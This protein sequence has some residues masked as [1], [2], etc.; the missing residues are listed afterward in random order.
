[1]T[2]SA[3]ITT[4]VVQDVLIVPNWAVQTDQTSDQIYTYVVSNGTPERVPITIGV[5]ND[6]LTQVTS[7]LDQGATVALVAEPTNLL[8]IQGPACA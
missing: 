3:T 2:A 1:M 6:T 4:G 7:G 8:S 5:R